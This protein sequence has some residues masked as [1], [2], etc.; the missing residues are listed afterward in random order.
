MPRWISPATLKAV[1]NAVSIAMN[2]ID[3][4]FD[5]PASSIVQQLGEHLLG[6]SLQD[7]KATIKKEVKTELTDAVKQIAQAA[8]KEILNS[9]QEPNA[10][11]VALE[12]NE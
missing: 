2:A 11:G 10:P 5:Q 1:E 12:Q 3:P 6:A 9:T 4:D 7:L 8:V